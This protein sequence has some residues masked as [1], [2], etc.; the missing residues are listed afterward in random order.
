MPAC[1]LPSGPLSSQLVAAVHLSLLTFLESAAPSLQHI[2]PSLRGLPEGARA[3]AISQPLPRLTAPTS[4]QPGL[5]SQH[6]PLPQG[7][8]QL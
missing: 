7:L 8:W 5:G 4:A 3:G 6:P 2:L 1:P